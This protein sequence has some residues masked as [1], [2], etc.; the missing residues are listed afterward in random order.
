MYSKKKDYK[1]KYLTR[2]CGSKKKIKKYSY[3]S[4]KKGGAKLSK[5][6]KTLVVSHNAGFFS[7]CTVKLNKII[8]YFNY[9]KQLPLILD[10]SK[11]YEYYK[12]NNE[13]DLTTEYFEDYN[14]NKSI[15]YKN[16][17][18]FSYTY[19][20]INYKLLCYDKLNS[21][22]SKYFTP[23]KDVLLMIQ[24]IEKKYKINYE[25]ICVLFFRGNDKKT[26]T[27][28]SNYNDYIVLAKERLKE[29]SNIRFLIQSDETEF[30]EKMLSVFPNS[31]YFKDE[32]RHMSKQNNTVDKVMTKNILL[33]SKYF[34]AITIIMSKCNYVICGSG[35]CSLWIMLY[36][37]NNKNVYQYLND[38]WIK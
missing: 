6:Q 5:S 10:C 19:Q 22:V 16:N 11:L 36:R 4:K 12:L 27:R 17:I 34:L 35:N 38:T 30:I 14:I 8:H 26:E 2:K 18:D 7:C 20:F 25:N 23:S 21:F 32:I 24:K 37:N 29:N 9:Y 33:Y 31:F 15:L 3:Y 1:K 28:L 13:H